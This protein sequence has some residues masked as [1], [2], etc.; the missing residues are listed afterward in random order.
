LGRE[1]IIERERR[2]ARPAAAAA[3][4][5]LLLLV[6][7]LIQR[8]SVPGEDR[9]ADQLEAF[10]DHAGALAASSVL[11]GVA[12]LLWTIPLLYLFRAAQARNPR[13]QRA[14]VAFCLI[15][16]A[17]IGAQNIVNGLAISNV[18]SDF[19]ER[20]D[21]EQQR[22]LSELRRQVADDPRSIEKVTFHTDSDTLEVEQADGAFYRTQYEP[23]AEDQLLR[24]VDTAGIDSED[25]AEGG[26]QDAFAERLLDDSGG[27]AVGRNLLFPAL[28][29]MIVVMVYTPLQALRAGLLTRFFATLGMA[30]GASLILLPQ[31]PVLIALWFGYLGLLFLGKVPGGRPPAWEAGEA[32][33]W[34][35]AGEESSPET[36]KSGEAIE[37]EATEVAAAGEQP[38]RPPGGQ[39]GSRKRK[40]KRR[41]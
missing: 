30:L 33:P 10:H 13:V 41:R 36:G 2:W 25:D 27:V 26:A 5:G 19:V 9:T 16:P 20:K 37:G 15:G 6:I 7:G 4:G 35:R 17:L 38:E 31:A 12:F 18:A 34:P 8:T 14:L 40:R 28:L 3:L 23:A 11:T 39:P 1:R 21:E 22:P 32:I 24:S 29:G